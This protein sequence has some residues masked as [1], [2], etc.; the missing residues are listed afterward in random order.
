MSSRYLTCTC[1]C[2]WVPQELLMAESRPLGADAQ[3]EHSKCTS[4]NCA[5]GKLISRRPG[6]RMSVYGRRRFNND[7]YNY[8][9]GMS[10]LGHR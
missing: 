3:S 7:M 10:P 4:L 5:A 1:T 9:P 2:T 8:N 6:L